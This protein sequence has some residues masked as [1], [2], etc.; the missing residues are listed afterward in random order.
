MREF[1]FIVLDEESM[2]SMGFA[3]RVRP[4][5]TCCVRKN[6]VLRIDCTT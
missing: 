4:S 2:T 5:E 6:H 3:L 1:G